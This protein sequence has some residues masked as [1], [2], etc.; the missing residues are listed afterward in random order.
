M[1]LLTRAAATL[2]LVVSAGY[3]SAA[4]VTEHQWVRA[5]NGAVKGR[6][7]VPRGDSISAVRGAKVHLLDQ[8]GKL[9][10][11]EVASDNTGRFTMSGVKPG[12][13]TLVIKGEHSFACCAMHVV[14]S[15]VPLKD[16]F[17]IA[18]GAVEAN[19]VR[20]VMM[21]YLPSSEAAQTEIVFDPSTNPLTTDRAQSGETIRIRQFEGGL[22]GH[23]AR[24]GFA[25]H[26]GSAQ[27]NVMIYKDGA[28]VARTMT[29]DEGNFWVSKL[30]PGSYTV[31][32]SG[33]DGFGV[34][35]VELVDPALVQT[36]LTKADGSTLVAVGDLPAT[37]VM[38]VAPVPTNE[39]VADVVIADEVIVEDDD[40]GAPIFAGGGMSGSVGG[41]G[42]GG[43]GIGGGGGLGR[44]GLLGGIGAAI[45]IAAS[46][47]D[48]TTTPPVA[49]PATP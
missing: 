29:D 47:D 22:K 43:G 46:D 44:I 23:I 1:N 25:D 35:G 16:Q 19:V 40:R 38:Q 14:D 2:A 30:S 6:V 27:S 42:A 37:F 7:V 8:S 33:R 41:G 39:V 9:V 26:L 11:G 32:G 3:S 21:R 20:S 24:A 12:V 49:S 18:A 5:T 10:I 17:E 28:E 4:D 48:D 31:I 45:A 13:Y 15:I 36:A 34:L